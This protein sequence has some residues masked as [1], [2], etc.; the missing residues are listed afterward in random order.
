[1]SKKDTAQ[2]WDTASSFLDHHL[3]VI[4]QVSTHTI[5]SYRAS[6][7][8]FIDYLEN[9]EHINRKKLTFHA[10]EKVILKRYLEWMVVTRKLSP[11]TCNLRMTAI[12]SLL[13][14]AAQEYLWIMPLYSDACT[15]VGVKT[16]NQPIEYFESDEMT[17][18]LATPSNDRKTD[19]RNK[20]M[21]IFLYDTAA[22]VSEVK[23]VKVSD[24]HLEA[25]VP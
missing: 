4:R 2:F 5:D 22:R 15:I 19:R 17:A 23:H 20:M 25:N 3:K 10:F 7:N 13:E 12:R 9:V 14:F 18:L 8:C 6:L 11:K 1:M 16:L 21:L 24:L